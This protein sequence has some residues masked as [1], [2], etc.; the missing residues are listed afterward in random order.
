VPLPLLEPTALLGH[1]WGTAEWIKSPR[2]GLRICKSLGCTIVRNTLILLVQAE[3]EHLM[4]YIYMVGFFVAGAGL[5]LAAAMSAR[6]VIGLIRG[7]PGAADAAF[8]RGDSLTAWWTAAQTPMT[9][10]SPRDNER[11]SF[12]A[13]KHP[14]FGEVLVE[15]RA[16]LP[17]YGR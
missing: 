9:L 17:S 14:E 8:T 6:V 12:S 2:G 16:S 5:A 11:L 7:G 13:R 15:E 4:S 10:D 1:T 3:D